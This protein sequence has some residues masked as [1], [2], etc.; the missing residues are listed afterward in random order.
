MS[1]KKYISPEH[2]IR[3]I[4]GTKIVNEDEPIIEQALPKVLPNPVGEPTSN[5]S[6]YKSNVGGKPPAAANINAPKQQKPIVPKRDFLKDLGFAISALKMIT[7]LG[8]AL[9]VM[10]P[11]AL[12]SDE[13]QYM[14]RFND[15][16]EKRV[17]AGEDPKTVGIDMQKYWSPDGYKRPAE[18]P[19]VSPTEKPL[20]IPSVAPTPAGTPS[21][22][23]PPSSAPGAAP[24]GA[25][26][27]STIIAPSV[28]ASPAQ[29]TRN[30]RNENN[31]NRPNRRTP[32]FNLGGGVATPGQSASSISGFE[33][34]DYLHLAKSR[35]ADL[36]A[37]VVKENTADDERRSIENVSRPKSD[38]NKTMTRNQEIKKKILDEN[39]MKKLIIKNAV[40]KSKDKNYS[41]ELN[42]EYNHEKLSDQ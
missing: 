19:D 37:K 10:T 12:G 40:K 9:T 33:S 17:K 26:A 8:A 27:P 3:D 20:E 1:D 15:E 11:T 35:L 22:E 24:A 34:P 14:K 7:P 41:V 39:E 21:P 4:M 16:Y 42:P 23:A 29:Q 32:F 30:N 31:K 18:I 25:P 36:P 2:A 28:S 38:R 6:P 13:D 5:Y